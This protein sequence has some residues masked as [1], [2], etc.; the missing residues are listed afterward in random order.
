MLH[1]CTHPPLYYT[2]DPSS[3]SSTPP[4]RQPHTDPNDNGSGINLSVSLNWLVLGAALFMMWNASSGARDGGG[5]GGPRHEISFQ[6]FRAKLLAKVRGWGGGL[7]GCR[8]C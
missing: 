2:T 5:P 7:P 1:W 6:E 8:P 4:H 3:C